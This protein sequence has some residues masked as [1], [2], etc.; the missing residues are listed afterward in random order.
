MKIALHGG[1]YTDNFGDLLLLKIFENWVTSALNSEAKY[2]YPMVPESELE[3]FQSRFINRSTGLENNRSWNS[4][5]YAGG[6]HFGQPEIKQNKLYN[7]YTGKLARRFF[8]QHVLPAELCIWKNIPYAVVGVEVGPLDNTFIRKEVKRIF[9]NASLLTVR[10]IESKEFVQKVLGIDSDIL[11]AP[12]PALI[13]NIED[14]PNYAFEYVENILQ[15]YEDKIFLGIHQ[16]CD[17][18]TKKPQTELLKNTLISSFKSAPDILPVV[19]SDNGRAECPEFADFIENATGKKCLY[20]SFRGIWET[21]AL[22]SRLSAVL[23]T[24]LHV[25]IVAYALGVYC[26]SFANHIKIPRFYRQIN[27]SSQCLSLNDLNKEASLERIE[28]IIQNARKKVSIKDETWKQIK[29]N[30]LLHKQELSSFMKSI[31]LQL[32]K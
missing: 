4:L 16:P 18:M 23:T 31:E 25:G 8:N 2:I 21:T 12:D 14:I 3:T 28:G 32:L 5:I 29:D 24:K 13:V 1:Y 11:V 27:R 19:F 22:I 7:F 17:F 6:G 26:E 10:N 30:A 15:P 20:V 9:Q